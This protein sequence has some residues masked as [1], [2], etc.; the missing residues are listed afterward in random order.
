MLL[1]AVRVDFNFTLETKKN[2]TVC[3]E[4]CDFFR[5]D[6]KNFSLHESTRFVKDPICV[7]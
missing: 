1:K 2:K 4:V 6:S 3:G 5:E 7:L